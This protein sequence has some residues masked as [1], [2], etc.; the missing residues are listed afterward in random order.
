MFLSRVS[1]IGHGGKETGLMMDMGTT[2]WIRLQTPD[3]RVS[4]HLYMLLY[5]SVAYS[6][7]VLLY[8]QDTLVQFDLDISSVCQ[9]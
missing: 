5:N 2:V 3:S 6:I 4:L 1:K 9:N 7:S 8:G